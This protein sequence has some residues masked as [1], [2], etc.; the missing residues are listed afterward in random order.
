MHVCMCISSNNFKDMNSLDW[1]NFC[2]LLYCLTVLQ[3][4]SKPQTVTSFIRLLIISEIKIL[5]VLELV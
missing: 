4:N 1:V 5:K 2:Y 3:D